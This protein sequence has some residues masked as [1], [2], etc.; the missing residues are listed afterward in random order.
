MLFKNQ[1]INVLVHKHKP[2]HC[3]GFFDKLLSVPKIQG[4]CPSIELRLKLVSWGPTRLETETRTHINQ[5]LLH[6][7]NQHEG[8]R[9]TL[10]A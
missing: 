5:S 2:R 4:T 9:D 8:E 10:I 3:A 7:S 1:Y 6:L